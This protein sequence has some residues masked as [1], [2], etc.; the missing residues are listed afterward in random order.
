MHVID[1]EPQCPRGLDC[2]SHRKPII[3]DKGYICAGT[4]RKGKRGPNELCICAANRSLDGFADEFMM[5][6]TPV[7]FAA[8]STAGNEMLMHWML[9]FK[10]YARWRRRKTDE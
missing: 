4:L 7:A 9:E 5:H 10:P 1:D 8:I 3:F 2:C 6:L